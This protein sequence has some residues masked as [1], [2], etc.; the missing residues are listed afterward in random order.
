MN[1][2]AHSAIG[3]GT[4]FVIAN[5]YG[6]DPMTTL[7]LV[8][9]GTVSALIPDLDI[10][11]KLAKKISLSDKMLKSVA[12]IIGLLM[13]VLSLVQVDQ[14]EKWLGFIIGGAIIFFAQKLSQK[15]MLILT[16][17]GVAVLGFFLSKLWLLLIGI[18]IVGAALSPH[19]SYTHS[20]IGLAFFA[21][22]AHLFAVDMNNDLLFY[23]CTFGYA[24]HLIADMRIFPANRRGI[25]LFLPFSKMD[26]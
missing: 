26:L 8:S 22:I 17:I 16:G 18:Y 6:A 4:G 7:A 12:T 9:A 19:R 21:Y 20:L 2:V 1:G 14:N 10:G 25:K 3:A 11:G 23:A 13:M 15:I 5:V 24:S